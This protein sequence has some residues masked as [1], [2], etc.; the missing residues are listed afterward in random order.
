MATIMAFYAYISAELGVILFTTYPDAINTGIAMFG[1][2]RIRLGDFG[3]TVFIQL[4]GQVLWQEPL[5][6]LRPGC[7][8]ALPRISMFFGQY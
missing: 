4:D 1:I 5:G 7:C 2:R 6:R 3:Q 8:L